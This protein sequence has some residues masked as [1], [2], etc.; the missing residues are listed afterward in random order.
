ML[1][2]NDIVFQDNLNKRLSDLQRP[3]ILIDRFLDFHKARI[4]KEMPDFKEDI[5][6]DNHSFKFVLM[7][8]EKGMTDYALEQIELLLDSIMFKYSYSKEDSTPNFLDVIPKIFK[9][10]Y[11]KSY[12]QTTSLIKSGGALRRSGYMTSHVE[13][14]LERI[15][16]LIHSRDE[17]FLKLSKENIWQKKIDLTNI[18]YKSYNTLYGMLS[19][20]RTI[21]DPAYTID[22]AADR[23]FNF[24]FE[25]EKNKDIHKIGMLYSGTAFLETEWAKKFRGDPIITMH[26]YSRPALMLHYLFCNTETSN[27][28]GKAGL[29]VLCGNENDLIIKHNSIQGQSI[30]DI[31]NEMKIIAK[32]DAKFFITIPSIKCNLKNHYSSMNDF[33]SKS[34]LKEIL[35]Y[36]DNAIVPKTTIEEKNYGYVHRIGFEVLEKT[37][38]YDQYRE[39]SIILKAGTRIIVHNSARYNPDFIMQLSYKGKLRI[40]EDESTGVYALVR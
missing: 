23:L 33:F 19:Y 18:G 22:E 25:K 3:K 8:L 14:Q 38:L 27:H 34:F 2:P 28:P 40:M 13:G 31:Y 4:L 6:L 29:G 21:N 32:S 7:Y 12:E 1:I 37:K 9:E 16:Q 24:Y 5:I 35:L 10:R 26:E 11:P 15:E 36:Y 17:L 20:C 30:K 39:K